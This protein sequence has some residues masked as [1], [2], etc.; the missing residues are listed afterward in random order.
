C[1]L[2][3]ADNAKHLYDLLRPHGTRAAVIGSA[4]CLGS[5]ERYLGMLAV[6]L[7]RLDAAAEHFEAA[8]AAHVRLDAPV[9]RAH[10]AFAYARLLP[11]PPGRPG[12]PPPPAC[13]GGPPSRE[14]RRAPPRSSRTRTPR[15]RRSGWSRCS[16]R[17]EKTPPCRRRGRRS[18]LGR[19]PRS[20][21]RTD[22]GG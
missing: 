12:L 19:R 7:G 8:L 13:S 22:T 16:A 9:Y 20:C 10:T 21:A 5:V 14:T 18:P 17:C 15:Q 6:T 4:V 11:R 2:D 1:G 3:D